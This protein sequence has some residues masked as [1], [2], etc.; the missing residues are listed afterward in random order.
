MSGWTNEQKLMKWYSTEIKCA[1]LRLLKEVKEGEIKSFD[2]TEKYLYV[3]M[4]IMALVIIA[5]IRTNLNVYHRILNKLW[6]ISRMDC[7]TIINI[8]FE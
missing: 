1:A 2:S 6:W 8:D 3:E 5:Q 7:N 4:F